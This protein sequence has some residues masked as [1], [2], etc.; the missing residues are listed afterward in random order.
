[1]G[2]CRV[3]RARVR[4]MRSVSDPEPSEAGTRLPAVYDGSVHK[5]W[6]SAGWLSGRTFHFGQGR[7]QLVKVIS[8]VRAR[9][10]DPG[11]PEPPTS[12]DQL[13][14]A[15]RRFRECCQFIATPPTSERQVQDIIWIMLRDDL[16]DFACIRDGRRDDGDG[17]KRP[18]GGD[19]PLG[20]DC[21]LCRLEANDPIEGGR[22]T[23]T[24]RS[25]GCQAPALRP[26]AAA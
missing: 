15:L 1:M 16:P 12:I 26:S 13:L 19:K 20:R 6:V 25:V 2:R 22:N 5:D 10:A 9:L 11:T 14:R 24:S 8:K 18:T 3:R 23:A 21:A 17:V 4:P 7:T